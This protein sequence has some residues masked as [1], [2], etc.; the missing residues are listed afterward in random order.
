MRAKTKQ[1]NNKKLSGVE[2]ETVL[3]MKLRQWILNSSFWD[4][5]LSIN[6]GLQC[7]L[8]CYY[9][10]Q[11]IDLKSCSKGIEAQGSI[12]MCVGL[13]TPTPQLKKWIPYVATL[14]I[15]HK[16]ML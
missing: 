11:W 3:S 7:F 4:V 13:Q 14:H 9:S 6:S 16:A 15:T 5:N 2:R 1:K 8:P 10:S 12:K